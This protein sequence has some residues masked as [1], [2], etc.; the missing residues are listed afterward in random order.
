MAVASDSLDFTFL[1][2]VNRVLRTNTLIR[3]DDD[4]VTTFSDV[5]HNASL[6]LAMIAIQDELTEISSERLIDLELLEGSITTS[7]GVRAYALP[8]NFIRFSEDAFF[9]RASSNRLVPEYPGGR[10]KL[11]REI[12][13]YKTQMGEPNWWYC[14]PSTQK[15]VGF[16]QVPNQAITYTY[17][18]QRSLYVSVAA[19][20]M[21]F[22]N[23]EEADSFCQMASRRFKYMFERAENVQVRVENDAI[24]KSAKTRLY[25]LFRPTRA[26]RAYG[27]MYV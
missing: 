11:R 18:Y 27:R 20:E 8:T 22:H 13:D 9:Y 17:D 26:P 16:F 25:N 15:T 23:Q 10:A 19:D 1:D 3:G 6:N 5:Q 7:S 12:Y 4:N 24:Y 2:A 14:E 21:P